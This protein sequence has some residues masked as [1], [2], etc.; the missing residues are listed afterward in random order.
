[1]TAKGIKL[2]EKI[3]FLYLIPL[4]FIAWIISYTRG[5]SITYNDAMSHLDLSRLVIDNIQPGLAQLGGAWLPLPHILALSLIWNN[6][7]WHSG[8]A[9]SIFCMLA[10]IISVIALYQTTKLLTNSYLAAFVT[11]FV[12]A[13]NLNILYLQTTPLL[14]SLYLGCFSVSI[15]F[16]VRWFLYDEVVFLSLSS[17]FGFLSIFVRY[18]G[19]FVTLIQA[20][21]V[22]FSVLVIKKKSFSEAFGKFLIFIVPILFA[23]FLWFLWNLLIFKDPFYFFLGHYS[24][25][26]QQFQ[27]ETRAG[28]I[29]H[30]NFKEAFLAYWYAVLDN[31]G[32]IVIIMATIGIT[33]FLFSRK[34]IPKIGGKVVILALLFSPIAFNVL[35]LYFGFSVL[36]VP[37]LNW[38]PGG[39]VSGLWFNVRYGILALPFFAVCV[40]FIPQ[41]IS[42][43]ILK[44]VTVMMLILAVLLQAYLI[45]TAGIITVIDGTIGSSQFANNDIAKELQMQV[46][47]N[48]RILLSTANFNSVAFKSGLDLKQFV[49][50]G[51][52][53]EWSEALTQPDKYVTWIVIANGDIG[54]SAYTSL[55]KL[56]KNE[57]LYF[58]KLAYAGDH[59]N[60]YKLRTSNELF[61][62]RLQ[63]NLFLGRDK[64]TI[65]GVNSYDLAYDSDNDINTT[66]KL[67][68][69][70]KINTLRFWLFGDGIDDGFQ[71]NAGIM[72]ENRFKKTDLIIQ[73]A[74][75]YHIKLIPVLL[76]NWTDYGGIQQ[77]LKWV[78]VKSTINSD[79]YT[80]RNAVNLY[81]NYINHVLSRTNTLTN[82]KYTD[83]PSILGWDIMNEPQAENSNEG[84]SL[85]DWTEAISTYIKQ[86]D[87]NHLVFIGTQTSSVPTCKIPNIDICS[88]HLYLYNGNQPIYTGE[89]QLDN[90]L[91]SGIASVSGLIKPALVEELGIPKNEKPF[92]NNPLL[93]LKQII[94]QIK[95]NG[96]T[97][98]LI[99]N[100]SL[101][102]DSSFGF[103][104]SGDKNGSY[105]LINL[106]E[107]Y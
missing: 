36:N 12:Y 16:F 96:Y 99:W 78:G 62:R 24:A 47:P 45:A 6:W 13:A 51:V 79:F 81:E 8:F 74:Q 101:K 67:L 76:N 9:G 34:F 61:V 93:V 31:I 60:I 84:R 4:S 44:K 49:H 39:N 66:F 100:W 97:G 42:G 5:I 43:N 11:A 1:M 55:V 50:E 68:S 2:L 56:G 80:N 20:M 3:S 22:L 33:V 106:K 25:R 63:N 53:D 19:W 105:S 30:G 57:F 85:S 21:L 98:F 104:P 87:P 29:T 92:G 27:I 90:S 32:L 7:A 37:E 38:N 72:N 89:Q 82:T 71:P 10:Y 23:M 83:E 52:K 107:L 65:Q 75:K 91:N 14:E 59:A 35:A 18:D 77:Y 17:F 26:A 88:I 86:R 48:E 95:Q 28:L 58:Y 103:S 64:F 70:A 102:P 46:K 40:G 41:F 94:S 15:Y 73:D 69:T 54:E